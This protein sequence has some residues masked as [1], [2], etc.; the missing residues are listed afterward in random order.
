VL[1]RL[2]RPGSARFV[3][4]LAIALVSAC[5]FGTLD[6]EGKLCDASG[7]CAIGYVCEAPTQRCLKRTPDGRVVLPDGA[8]VPEESVATDGGAGNGDSSVLPSM[9]VSGKWVVEPSGVGGA[10]HAVA[11]NGSEAYAVGTG[12]TF[13][14]RERFAPSWK[15]TPSGT[16]NDLRGVFIEGLDVCAGG[17]GGAFFCRSKSTSSSGG[18]SGTIASQNINAV[19]RPGGK[20]IVAGDQGLMVAG[21][22]PLALAALSKFPAD[23]DWRAVAAHTAQVVF[24]VSAQGSLARWTESSFSNRFRSR[25]D[26]TS[27]ATN[28][29]DT[30]TFATAGRSV[31]RYDG[32]D[33][34][35]TQVS[36]MSLNGIWVSPSGAAIAVGDGGRIYGFDGAAWKQLESGT[37]ENLRAVAGH[38]D[39]SIIVAVG[40]NGT[41]VTKDN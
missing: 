14:Q 40:D 36:D 6:L 34:N 9:V 8:V 17:V 31:L 27:V 10:L 25:D 32:D 35:E 41:I 3:R 28:G 22:N 1:W 21:N 33:W 24:A 23:E 37:T 2:F 16:P 7:R 4:A 18:F 20:Y 13:V 15:V 11:V 19:A 12:G 29:T 38:L 26:I 5:G 30:F 39:T